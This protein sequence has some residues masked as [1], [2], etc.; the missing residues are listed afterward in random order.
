MGWSV[1]LGRLAE[2]YKGDMDKTVR[3]ATVLAAQK[4]VLRTPVG[5]VNGGRL[6]AN[7]TFQ[8][9][10]I[11]TATTEST[12]GLA[13]LANITAQINA[14]QVGGRAYISNSLPYAQRI[15]Y[16]GWSKVKAPQGMV[17]ISLA[18]MPAAIDRLVKG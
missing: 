8:V 18:E 10:S 17:R 9:G 5:D 14:S 6:R 4:V 13:V 12:D 11:N 15:E 3:A 7:W 1:D 2:K 16:E